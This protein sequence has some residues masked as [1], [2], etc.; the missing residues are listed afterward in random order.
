M[1]D[2]A[3][4][5]HWCCLWKEELKDHWGFMTLWGTRCLLCSWCIPEGQQRSERLWPDALRGESMYSP[6]VNLHTLLAREKWRSTEHSY[7]FLILLL[8]IRTQR[9]TESNW[10]FRATPSKHGRLCPGSVSCTVTKDLP[11]IQTHS[12]GWEESIL[13]M[14]F[15]KCWIS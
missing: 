5:P 10:I 14:T 2:S 15:Y 1:R 3:G 7:D 4:D 8:D 6:R 9:S 11:G 12:M 13:S